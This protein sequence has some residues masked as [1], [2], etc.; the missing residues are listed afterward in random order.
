MGLGE[1][2]I[3]RLELL[4]TLCRLNPHPDSVPINRLTQVP[5]TPLDGQPQITSWEMIRIVAVARLVMPEAIVRLSC[6]RIEM[7]YEQQALCFLAG[8]N[9]IH[10]GE[11][12]LTVTNPSFDK[13]EAMF[14]LLG[15]KKRKANSVGN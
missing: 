4:L 1:E 2:P 8:A 15:L 12:L 10:A 13:D 11:K 7:S 3:D 14:Q 5:G 6:G 9:S